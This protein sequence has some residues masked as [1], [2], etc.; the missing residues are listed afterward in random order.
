MLECHPRETIVLLIGLPVTAPR[1]LGPHLLANSQSICWL[2]KT[3]ANTIGNRYRIV[4]DRVC[5][6]EADQCNSIR[7]DSAVNRGQ[8]SFTTP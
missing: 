1:S 8:E 5:P 3:R 2:K 7:C 4:K 6:L